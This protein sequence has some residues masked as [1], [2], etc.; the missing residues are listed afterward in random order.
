MEVAVG[1]ANPPRER[2]RELGWSVVSSEEISQTAES[3][4]AYV[5]GSRGEF[6]VAKNVYV[7]TRS[8]W[9][10][11]RSACYLAAGRPV[12][13][14][15]TGFSEILPT[16]RGVFAFT[17]ADEAAAAI[18]TVERSYDEHSAHAREFAREHLASEV[19]LSALLREVG[20]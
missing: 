15:D 3:Y 4:R 19:V 8:G 14:Q 6:S 11:C 17:T 16:G 9:F 2:W 13:L 1:G 18:A 20:L 12:V 5:A 10:S 7:A